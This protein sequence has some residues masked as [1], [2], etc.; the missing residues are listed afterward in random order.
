MTIFLRNNNMSK[1]NFGLSMVSISVLTA[2][3]L[4]SFNGQAQPVSVQSQSASASGKPA[5]LPL[6][7]ET[8]TSQA[9]G[10][11]SGNQTDNQKT[12]NVSFS[13]NI[14]INGGSCDFSTMKPLHGFAKDLPL[15]D[16]LKQ[17]TP[18]GWVVKKRDALNNKIDINQPVSWTGGKNWVE[19]LDQISHDHNI[20]AIVNCVNKEVVVSNALPVN[21]KEVL[22]VFEFAG[23]LKTDP[24]VHAESASVKPAKTEVAVSTT[25]KPEANPEAKPEAKQS[26]AEFVA[27]PPPVVASAPK[28]AE[29]K[30]TVAQQG[31]KA[32]EAKAQ[33]VVIP[34]GQSASKPAMQPAIQIESSPVKTVD[35]SLEN[36]PVVITSWEID[37]KKTLKENVVDWGKLVGYKVVWIGADYAVDSI[38]LKGEFASDDGPIKQL[39]FDYGP[40]SR[41]QQPLNFIFFNNKTLVVENLKYEQSGF[42][43]F[44]AKE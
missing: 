16:V 41:V 9:P 44:S 32:P 8:P 17:I 38:V 26:I 24:S 23:D 3:S 28:Q 27:L 15:I 42:P 31:I 39:A 14:S 12:Q 1:T 7:Q 34:D 18:D 20:N 2:L 33:G 36:K 30:P 43:Q 25:A 21:K 35:I 11:Q 22:N 5:V 37:E 4:I 40:G 6:K 10:N 13:Q 19:T 29:T